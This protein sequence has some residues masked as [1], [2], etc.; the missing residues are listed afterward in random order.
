LEITFKKL[1]L[2]RKPIK[3]IGE[4]KLAQEKIGQTTK[5]RKERKENPGSSFSPQPRHCF[6]VTAAVPKSTFPHQT[7]NLHTKF[8]VAESGHCSSASEP[9]SYIEVFDRKEN[10]ISQP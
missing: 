3:A 6:G 7:Q 1:P 9:I 10:E 2:L 8:F 4:K 5:E